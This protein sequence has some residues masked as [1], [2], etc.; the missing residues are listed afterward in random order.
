MSR[1]KRSKQFVESAVQG[2]LVRR[3]VCHWILVL[4]VS[5]FL[6]IGLRV[7]ADPFQPLGTHFTAFIREHLFF[8]LLM[9][10]MTPIFLWDTI[11]L[12]NRFAGPVMRVH[13]AMR[14]LNEGKAVKEVKLRQGDFWQKLADEFNCLLNKQESV[15][16]IGLETKKDRERAPADAIEV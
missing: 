9:A 4:V 15:E 7:L 16:P 8:I 2:A 1:N 5:T 10:C 14:D 12:S 6:L 13:R 3:M 11:K